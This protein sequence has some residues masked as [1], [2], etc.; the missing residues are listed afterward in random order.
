MKMTDQLHTP[1]NEPLGTCRRGLRSAQGEED[2]N[3][4]PYRESNLEPQRNNLNYILNIRSVN[5]ITY[6]KL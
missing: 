1:E 3:I 6:R 2:K 5:Q 4:S